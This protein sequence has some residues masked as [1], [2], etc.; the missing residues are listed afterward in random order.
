MRSAPDRG[1]EV[2]SVAVTASAERRVE[3]VGGA[4]QQL[5]EGF[6]GA[7]PGLSCALLDAMADVNL[8]L[9]EGGFEI[10]REFIRR[11]PD[12]CYLITTGSPERVPVWIPD[13]SVLEKP[14]RSTRLVEEVR[15]RRVLPRRQY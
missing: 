11:N 12:G 4:I 1:L 10:V 2:T 7:F 9:Q 5:P 3:I 8:D 6:S 15:K 14:F 13:A